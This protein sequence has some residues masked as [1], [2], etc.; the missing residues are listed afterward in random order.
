MRLDFSAFWHGGTKKE[1]TFSLH[2]D[3]RRHEISAL[4]EGSIKGE[5]IF[6]MQTR[7][8][9]GLTFLTPFGMQRQKRAYLQF[10]QT[11]DTR[12]DFS[13]FWQCGTKEELTFILP[14]QLARCTLW[15][16][17]GRAYLQNAYADEKRLA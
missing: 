4:R 2:R 13:A 6:S 9:H 15:H 14:T 16:C 11:D 1:L 5:Y 8:T 3:S 7:M 17:Q 12:L 10:A